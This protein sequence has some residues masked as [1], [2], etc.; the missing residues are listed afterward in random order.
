MS[1][2]PGP[3]WMKSRWRRIPSEPTDGNR[4]ARSVSPHQVLQKMGEVVS[5]VIVRHAFSRDRVATNHMG[6][7]FSLWVS[8]T[9]AL[10]MACRAISSPFPAFQSHPYPGD[11]RAVRLG[12]DGQSANPRASPVAGTACP[13]RC[14]AIC[15]GSG[16]GL[17]AL[18]AIGHYPAGQRTGAQ[19]GQP[20]LLDQDD[21]CCWSAVLVTAW[22]HLSVRAAHG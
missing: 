6:G 17:V 4:M 2:G 7:R 12:A 3:G 13:R 20:V 22:F 18:I 16:G 19:H 8:N 14:S 5:D 21:R 10:P 9:A 15:P 11:R 1:A